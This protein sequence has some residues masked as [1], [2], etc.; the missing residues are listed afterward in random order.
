MSGT[1]TRVGR[2]LN[3]AEKA[4]LGLFAGA[5]AAVALT[6]FGF[7]IARVADLLGAA[8]VTL[9]DVPLQAPVDAALAG[10]TY[11]RVDLEVTGLSGGGVAALGA[12]TVTQSLLLIGAALV[13]AWL[14]L[15]IFLRRPFAR[16]ATWGLGLVSILTLVTGLL[17]PLFTGIANAEAAALLDVDALPA[18]LI[19]ISP[20]HIGCGLALAVV[21][22]AF[23]IGQRM[24]RDVEGLI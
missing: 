22:G 12:A 6:E 19:E 24:Q 13:V 4:L 3:L 11:D 17:N 8:H 9:D 16:S 20:A 15:R 10:A 21:A 7:L 18:F 1:P 2:A 23:E 5:G 14:S